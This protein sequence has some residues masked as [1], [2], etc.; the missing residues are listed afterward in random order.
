[1]LLTPRGQQEPLRGAAV[2]RLWLPGGGRDRREEAELRQSGEPTPQPP[3]EPYIHG[4]TW[5]CLGSRPAGQAGLPGPEVPREEP[6]D[7]APAAGAAQTRGGRS[8]ALRDRAPHGERRGAGRVRGHL[9]GSGGPRGRLHRQPCPSSCG[10]CGHTTHLSTRPPCT[11]PTFLPPS[12][13]HWKHTLGSRSA[14]VL[15]TRRTTQM[16]QRSM[17]SA[18]CRHRGVRFTRAPR[19]HVPHPQQVRVCPA[20][21][22]PSFSYCPS[23]TSPGSLPPSHGPQSEPHPLRPARNVDVPGAVC[24]RGLPSTAVRVWSAPVSRGQSRSVSISVP[25]VPGTEKHEIMNSVNKGL[26]S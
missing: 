1:M 14:R 21:S 3:W 8:P 5:L 22:H 17:S 10:G 7:H 11:V 13:P 12:R 24:R 9:P 4:P 25:L 20:A 16:H 26:L 15:T 19:R 2:W 23:V 18:S 6:P